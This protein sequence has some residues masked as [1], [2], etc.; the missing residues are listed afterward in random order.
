MFALKGLV[1]FRASGFRFQHQ[2]SRIL[3]VQ[4]LYHQPYFPAPLSREIRVSF[5]QDGAEPELRILKR[6]WLKETAGGEFRVYI[7]LL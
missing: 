6:A 4:D 7:G 1:G 3:G 5:V 2:G